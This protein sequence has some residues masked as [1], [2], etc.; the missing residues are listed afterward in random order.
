MLRNI[1]SFIFI[2]IFIVSCDD[3]IV[4]VETECSDC[5]LELTFPDL[6]I[7][8][9]GYY[10]LDYNDNYIQTFTRVDAQVG[11]DYEYVGWTSNGYYCFEW[12]NAQQ[13]TELVNTS[14]YSGSD[15]IASTILAVRDI[16]IGYTLT[17]YAGYYD[18]YG[19]QHLDSIKVVID[20]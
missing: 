13:C 16:H 18:D 17:V 6:E 5:I 7:E 15:G 2:Y 12:M 20:E 14:S 19:I 4:G 10:H 1:V 9:D 3:N 8:S 11:H